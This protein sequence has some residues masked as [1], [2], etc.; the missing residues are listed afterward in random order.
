M[1]KPPKGIKFKKT[2]NDKENFDKA[3]VMTS[4]LVGGNN[5]TNGKIY[6]WP[7]DEYIQK[8]SKEQLRSLKIS[9]IRYI[10]GT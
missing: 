7:S 6:E 9:K 4:S 2:I 5:N 3:V 10:K 1:S 8:L